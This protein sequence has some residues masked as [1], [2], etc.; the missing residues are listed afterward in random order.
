MQLL[1]EA[2]TLQ[3]QL[4]KIGMMKNINVV[5]RKFH[6]YISNRNV[7]SAIKL[8]S[9]NM[10][11]RALRLNKESI[12]LLKVRYPVGKAAREETKL[13]GLLPTIKNIIVDFINDS[14]VLD[15]QR[16]VQMAGDKSWYQETLVM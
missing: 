6:E 3:S 7:N 16:W 12:A 5:S 8:P 15:H 2:T 14:M 1:G 10:K 11:G 9:N 4:R 13:R